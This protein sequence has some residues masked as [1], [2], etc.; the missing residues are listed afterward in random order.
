MFRPQI[1]VPVL[2]AQDLERAKS[3]YRDML[4]MQPEEAN[5]FEA[6]YRAGGVDFFLFRSTGKASG[7]HSQAAFLVD[8]LASTIGHLRD[9]GVRFEDYDLP[10]LKTADGIAEFPDSRRAWFKDSEGNLITI[11]ERI[12]RDPP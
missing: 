12:A 6:R 10:R 11:A 3:F 9:R 5:E 7:D 8:D 2:P 4:G 1:I